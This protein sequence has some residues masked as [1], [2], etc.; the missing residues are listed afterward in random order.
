MKKTN[1]DL[2]FQERQR[3]YYETQRYGYETTINEQLATNLSKVVPGSYYTNPEITA[4]VGLSGVPVDPKEIHS[5]IQKQMSRDG[6]APR[7][8][9]YI[10]SQSSTLSEKDAPTP[11]TLVDLL[12][13]SDQDRMSY[14][15]TPK[16]WD[17]V[18]P[19]GL[20]RNLPVPTDIP[21]AR[22]IWALN[23]AQAVK[24]FL[25]MPLEKW[26]EIP[27]MKSENIYDSKG[28]RLPGSFDAFN[29]LSGKFPVLGQM[30]A[31]SAG[32]SAQPEAWSAER[33][34]GGLF[35]SFQE[36]MRRAIATAQLPFKLLSFM[37]P[38][39]IGPAGGVNV[40]GIN[41]P[42]RLD[43]TKVGDTARGALRTALVPFVAAQQASK[44]TYEQMLAEPDS[45][46][47]LRLS[48]ATNPLGQIALLANNFKDP[49][50]RD[51]FL[52]SV[53]E[54]NILTQ[55]AKDAIAGEKLDLGSG[56]FPEGEIMRKAREAHDAGLPKVGGRT[57]TFGNAAIEPLIKEEY[58]DRDGYAAKVFSGILDGVFTVAT[59]P[60]TFTDPVRS[61]MGKFNIGDSAATSALSGRMYDIVKENLAKQAA[62]AR[63]ATE[64]LDIVDISPYAA[65]V[66]GEEVPPFAGILPPGATLPDDAERLAQEMAKNTID[67]LPATITSGK[68]IDIPSYVSPERSR[69]QAMGLTV[70]DDGT[71]VLDPMKID[72][73]PYTFDGRLT[74]NKIA[75]FKSSGEMW[76][77]F[78]GEI[79]PGLAYRLFGV[80]N[81]ARK[82][83]QEIDLNELHAVL[84]EGV[85]SGDPFYSIR[86]TPGIIRQF[87][88]QT[89]K[90][91]A[92]Y[93]YN[94]TRQF[95][96]HPNMTF[97]SFEDPMG[98]L[99]DMNKIM[100]EMRVPS[101]TRHEMLSSAIRAVV[102][103]EV[104]KRFDLQKQFTKTVIQEQLRKSGAPEEWIDT[105]SDWAGK[106]NAP[107]QWA[108]DAFGQN[109]PTPWFADGTGEVLR[110]TD[111][112]TK[113]FMMVSP[114]NYRRVIRETSQ[115]ARIFKKVRGNTIVEN[116]LNPTFLDKLE[117]IQSAYVKPVALGAPLP[118]RMVTRIVPDE[119]MR[120][121]VSEGLD[122]TSL[123]ALGMAGHINYNT[124]GVELKTAKEIE[125]LVPIVEELDYLYKRRSV[126]R[127]AKDFNTVEITDLRIGD[128]EAQFGNKKD[129]LKQIETYNERINTTLPGSGR[130]VVELAKGLMAEERGNPQYLIYER[131]TPQTVYKNVAYDTVTGAPIIDPEHPDNLR[132]VIGT[133]RDIVQMSETREYKQVALALL[134]GGPDAVAKLTERFL[135]GDLK[136]EFKAIYD[137]IVRTQGAKSMSAITP[138]TS[139]E[140][141]AMW[142]N[143][144]ARDIL[145]RTAG[146]KVAIAAVA[147]GKLGKNKIA[148]DLAVN[149]VGSEATRVKALNK[150]R[151]AQSF[152]VYES[153]DEFVQW[154]RN[155]LLEHPNSPPVA[156]FAPDV[157]V[158]K[159]IEKDNLMTRNFRW[160]RNV[161]NRR[162]RGPLQVYKKWQRV[163][164]LIP[165]MDPEEARLMV[166]G[167]DKT[168]APKWM[169]NSLRDELP[170][171]NGKITRKEADLL[172]DMYGN[173]VVDDLLY[174]SA[175]KSYFGYRHSLSLAFFDAWKEQ[176]SVW[177]RLMATHPAQ[178][179]KLRLA[180]EGLTGAELP[181]FA[182]GVS[183]NHIMFKDEDSGDYV[184]TA[185]LSK[186]LYE[187]FG[188]TADERIRT[189]QLSI[190]GSATPGAFGAGAVIL[191]TFAP[192]N[193]AF[194]WLRNLGFSFGD[195]KTKSSLADFFVP[196]WAQAIVGGTLAATG[197]TD[198]A[199]NFVQNVQGLL[200]TDTSDTTLVN[201]MNGIWQNQAQNYDGPPMTAKERQ[202]FLDDSVTKAGIVAI[203]VKGLARIVSP[204]SSY[205]KFFQN[206][207]SAPV[208]SGRVLDDLRTFTDEAI[209]SGKSYDAGLVKL[210]DTYGPS[211]WVYLA[212]STKALPGMQ[213]TKEF[214]EWERNNSDLLNKYPL[215]AGYLGPQ[216]GEYDPK[217]YSQ[218]RSLGLREQKLT[219][220]LQQDAL[221]NYGWALYNHK[222]E[223]LIREA[224]KYGFAEEDVVKSKPYK[225]EMALQQEEIKKIIPTWDLKYEAGMGENTRDRRRE[226]IELMVNDKKVLAQPAGAA[227]KEYWD[228][229]STELAKG[230][231]RYPEM[232][233]EGW[234]SNAAWAEFR[235]MLRNKGE[236]L[237]KQV[238]EFA[239][240]WER[241]LSKEYKD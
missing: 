47:G 67:N 154:V 185:P 155:N 91:L 144:I 102:E 109:M 88:Q 127:A 115:L 166:E 52:K 90:R 186:A 198:S 74:L 81:K 158:D 121:A 76:D 41:V 68:E 142:V 75:S 223:K 151:T 62:E 1:E 156:P 134:A 85:L 61:I 116:L 129:L 86:E 63:I 112:M 238:P 175:N 95:A 128:L 72:A 44:S 43:L 227:L 37:A 87:V 236:E 89:G 99:K 188:M 169:V 117:R 162:A 150:V 199:S 179:E 100:I 218:Q 146:D 148:L 168:D 20:W 9:S 138:L 163:R 38:D 149:T 145:N 123:K 42:S 10:S 159:L 83:G 27:G 39:H 106:T 2:E 176:W 122:E 70:R 80:V 64:G 213:A 97:F 203:I 209:K 147:T 167:L 193:A 229:R 181:S 228:F 6:M 189:K 182:G 45:L 165:A 191:D 201:L 51:N 139:P 71:A 77:Y 16:W 40:A 58:I 33:I 137:H 30:W 19:G 211:A 108:I 55:L 132:W 187:M 205:T 104:G 79:P 171:A 141:N 66:I 8:H 111:M 82:F 110:T 241:V 194:S 230:I 56:Y 17:E 5:N 204:T 50:K 221:M 22:R 136:D 164:E 240:L 23:E 124:M 192:N 202:Q 126:A 222:S 119:M 59:D 180:K 18:D 210:L 224:A 57:W 53:V 196:S 225:Q 212:G 235:Q 120:V 60:A 98:S 29:D 118:V 220:A 208:T 135:N 217:A 234:T 36:G 195:P 219:A 197:K 184:V 69:R 24:L 103:G 28:N 25:S 15:T 215:I 170:R 237:A 231:A 232:A 214:G 48:L 78:L 152:N 7:D 153:T 216:D 174:N 84:K 125:K 200:T 130:K 143:T 93:T 3:K 31:A 35:T 173:K 177:L 4:S 178:M 11:F 206:T 21:H 161:S 113:G 12:R 207:N 131:Q 14:R 107:Y 26:M 73:M 101:A 140:G 13:I 32:I 92:F 190:L 160:Y 226:Q 65:R 94:R 133:A 46:N 34:A 114:E 233:N 239:T 49:E 157:A 105:V 172:G 54:G 96:S 183:T